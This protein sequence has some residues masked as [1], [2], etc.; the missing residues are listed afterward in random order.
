MF[1][2]YLGIKMPAQKVYC[3]VKW[4]KLFTSKILLIPHMAFWKIL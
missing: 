2:K 3:I 1:F 4:L